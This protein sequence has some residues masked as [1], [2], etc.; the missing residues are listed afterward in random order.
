MCKNS[1]RLFSSFEMYY[2]SLPVRMLNFADVSLKLVDF[3]FFARPED[4]EVTVSRLESQSF[5]SR[6]V[7]KYGVSP[8]CTG[9]TACICSAFLRSA[10][11][12]S[13]KKFSHYLYLA[14]ANNDGYHFTVSNANKIIAESENDTMAQAQG[15]AFMRTCL[16]KLLAADDQMRTVQVAVLVDPPLLEETVVAT[17]NYL[18]NNMA[19]G[20]ILVHVDEHRRMSTNAAFRRGALSMLARLV[21]RVTVVATYVEI[22]I[23]ISG[24][25][26]SGVCR[27]AVP[28]PVLDVDA[29]TR[30]AR[31]VPTGR[32]GNSSSAAARRGMATLKFRLASY[33][34]KKMTAFHLAFSPEF[35]EDD[36][37]QGLEE[38]VQMRELFTVYGQCLQDT[39]CV[40]RFFDLSPSHFARGDVDTRTRQLFLGMLETDVDKLDER[41]KGHL[42][43]IA[44]TTHGEARLS[45]ALSDLMT[46]NPPPLESR[47]YRHARTLFLRLM[48]ENGQDWLSGTPLERAYLWALSTWLSMEG[49]I[50]MVGRDFFLDCQHVRSGRIFLRNNIALADIDVNGIEE[51]TIYYTDE[52]GGETSHPIGDIFF[53]SSDNELVLIDI[54]ASTDSS[55]AMTKKRKHVR[56]LATLWGE[57]PPNGWSLVVVVVSPLEKTAR[58]R[59]SQQCPELRY[60]YGDDTKQLLGGLVQFMAWY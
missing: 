9:K 18:D 33:L 6:A 24:E 60:V 43:A 15:A 59:V 19:A 39:R 29:T 13:P 55:N 31:V 36:I 20:R 10:T 11:S 22:P 7:V 38:V 40:R 5:A 1:A 25:N 14:F 51:N 2:N 41:L 48:T 47:V 28:I 52:D 23:E 56:E 54:T 32:G 34:T 37:T 42:V 44:S 17:N 12:E 8:T 35:M 58:S 27:D 26:S 49:C 4:M 3:P 21:R 57:D 16:Q 46:K 50:H 30:Y 45:Y 53:L